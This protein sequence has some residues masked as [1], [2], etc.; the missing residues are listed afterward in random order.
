[1]RWPGNFPIKVLKSDDDVPTLAVA[2]SHLS[3]PMSPNAP[4]ASM[5][6]QAA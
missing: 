5:V 2:G 6:S 4:A 1:M 3:V